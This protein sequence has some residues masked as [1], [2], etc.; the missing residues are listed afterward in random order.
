MTSPSEPEQEEIFIV[1]YAKFR[2]DVE[3][4]SQLI[5]VAYETEADAKYHA[6]VI[7]R[8]TGAMPQILQTYLIRKPK[9]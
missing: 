3:R 4:G 1:V 7:R 9:A 8:N 2:S 6:F 5:A